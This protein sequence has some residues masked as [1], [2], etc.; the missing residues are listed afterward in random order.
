MFG[1]GKKKN[2]PPE[3]LAAVELEIKKSP[4]YHP[5]D[6]SVIHAMP[7]IVVA[8]YQE[9]KQAKSAGM[10]IIVAGG[11]ILLVAVTGLFYYILQPAPVKKV[12]EEVATTT[13]EV[14]VA[15]TT[16]P[17]V[18]PPVESTTTPIV[19]TAT[20]TATST[21]EIASTSTSTIGFIATSTDSTSTIVVVPPVRD[22]DTDN[23]GLL[24]AEE[25]VFGTKIDK[26]DSDGD[27]FSD[28]TEI[29]RGYNPAGVGK[30]SAGKAFK[31][32]ENA[33]L[34][35]SYPASWTPKA[36]DNDQVVFE[37]PDNQMVQISIQPNVE[38]QTVLEWYRANVSQKTIENSQLLRGKDINGNITWDAVMSEDGLTYYVVDA[39]RQS[40]VTINYN[41]GPSNKIRYPTVFRLMME[42]FKPM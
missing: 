13:E 14:V 38:N 27:G 22:L 7:Q 32:F 4:T 36:T 41:L 12:V 37:G 39:L 16:E 30:L 26:T 25:L 6:E 17:E 34:G 8:H 42:S 11:L 28:M 35:I 19:E 15:T 1:F 29:N 40:I 2:T 20:T 9:S 10:L 5:E 31:K 33:N 21:I 24:D 18:V 3:V 23:D